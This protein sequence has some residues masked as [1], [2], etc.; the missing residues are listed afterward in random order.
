MKF[1]G[2][3]SP[4]TRDSESQRPLALD[5]YS[6]LSKPSPWIRSTWLR[7]AGA[8]T[9]VL[10]EFVEFVPQPEQGP[11]IQKLKTSTFVGRKSCSTSFPDISHDSHVMQQVPSPP[12]ISFKFNS[13]SYSH[14]LQPSFNF[15]STDFQMIVKKVPCKTVLSQATN[16]STPTMKVVIMS[17][18]CNLAQ[19][20]INTDQCHA[21][22][23]VKLL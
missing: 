15:A 23:A 16:H 7:S 19:L 3:C 13:Q 20:G 17:S 8:L 2:I 14:A 21:N 22:V 18:L 9:F 5:V 10:N 1:V 4:L 6:A 12:P 11:A